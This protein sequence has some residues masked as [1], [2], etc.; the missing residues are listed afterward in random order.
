MSAGGFSLEE[1]L[2][3]IE[4]QLPQHRPRVLPLP[5]WLREQQQRTQ[6]DAFLVSEP[7]FLPEQL[8]EEASS[9]ELSEDLYRDQT[10]SA[11]ARAGD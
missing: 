7:D 5:S 6:D 1:L 8:P 10:D 4:A 2:A 3:N 9:V 11:R